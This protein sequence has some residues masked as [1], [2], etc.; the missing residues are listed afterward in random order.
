LTR[1]LHPVAARGDVHAEP[2]LDGDQV[3]VVIAEQRS[4]QVRLVELELEPRAVGD[5]GKVAPGHQAASFRRI[6]PVMLFGPAAT[7]VTSS[8]SPGRAFVS[9]CTDCSQGE[10]PT[11]CP[12]CLPLRSMR[13][14]VSEPTFERL[15]ASWC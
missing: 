5:C 6:A 15:N 10:R 7:S 8:R 9:T 12:A 13:I 14:C 2:V 11:I 3:A 4:E 1:D